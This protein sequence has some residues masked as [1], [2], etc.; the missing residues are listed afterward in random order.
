LFVFPWLSTVTTILNMNVIN[1]LLSFSWTR[2]SIQR[3]SPSSWP[4]CTKMGCLPHQASFSVPRLK[5]E[6]FILQFT[7][8]QYYQFRNRI[9]VKSS[10]YKF[11][12]FSML[13]HARFNSSCLWRYNDE[14]ALYNMDNYITI[15]IVSHRVFVWVSF[16]LRLL[17][18]HLV[19]T[20]FS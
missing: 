14:I 20:N 3:T 6:R 5:C 9:I 15:V 18:T 11:L 19:S 17:I 12:D 10:L 13:Y 16:D 2:R 7:H 1:Y 8:M 4:H